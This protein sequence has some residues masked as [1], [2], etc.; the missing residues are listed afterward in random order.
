MSAE[1]AL[2]DEIAK[3]V[4]DPLGFVRFIFPWGE[5]GTA[6]EDQEGP[7]TWQIEQL[8]YI[9]K[10]LQNDPTENIKDA[11]AS[12]HGVGKSALTSWI[13]LW[14]MSTRPQLSGVVTASVF[15]QLTSKTWREMH[16]WHQLALNQHWF[17]LTATTFYH[18]KYPKT[19]II[20]ALPNSPERSEAFA[21]LH[22]KH[23]LV[24]FDEA[25]G[26]ADKIWEVTYGAMTTE[27]CIWLVYGNPTLNTGEFRKCFKRNSIWN[28]R[29]VDARTARMANQKELARWIQKEGGIDNDFVR[30]RVLG[31]F[32]SA[33]S[34]QF[35]E[36]DDVDAA[37]ARD[38]PPEAYAYDTIIIGC[39]IARKGD[40]ASVII[41][42]QG[43]KVLSLQRY[44]KLD[45]MAIGDKIIEAITHYRPHACFV[46]VVG[47]GSGTV[48]YL[49]RLNYNVIEVN[50]G[51][52]AID[53]KA[54]GNR[55]I[56]M[57]GNMKQWLSEGAD[58][59][60]DDRLRDAL[61][62]PFFYFRS[63]VGTGEVLM[64]ESKDDLRRRG[65]RSPDEADALAHTFYSPVVSN[66]IRYS[67][68]S[69]YNPE[70]GGRYI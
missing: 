33:S 69:V 36:S 46:D 43:K 70:D 40:D 54:Y 38:I 58:L 68:Q 57:W 19:W 22:A 11:T 53:T 9:G 44:H 60:D 65:I 67:Q 16:V 49:H 41:V 14:A 6:L 39:D 12:G 59:P 48:D 10:T 30:V 45:G 4:Y 50:A 8:E 3:Y 42:R 66:S 18:K 34:A 7:D 24:I 20:H 35:I 62:S 15:K 17:T 13:C 1:A 47:T 5:P 31:E 52:K 21:G 55:R 32:P 63:A 28:H 2:Q 25:S 56:E 29:R 23:V 26:V 27:G 51:R 61:T 64:L 37:M